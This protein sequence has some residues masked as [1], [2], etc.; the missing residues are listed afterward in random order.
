MIVDLWE[1]TRPNATDEDGITTWEARVSATSPL[2][3]VIPGYDNGL[4]VFPV[5]FDAHTGP[6]PSAGDLALVTQSDQG[7]WWLLAWVAS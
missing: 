3:V 4:H 1:A 2:R 5:V 7:S 6:S